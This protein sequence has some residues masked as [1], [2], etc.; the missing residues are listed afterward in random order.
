M[1]WYEQLTIQNR[2]RVEPDCLLCHKA[3]LEVVGLLKEPSKIMKPSLDYLPSI[4]SIIFATGK[5]NKKTQSIALKNLRSK[6]VA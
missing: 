1:N 3:C 4:E 5:K 6:L 2:F